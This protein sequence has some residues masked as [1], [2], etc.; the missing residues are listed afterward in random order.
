VL[1]GESPDARPKVYRTETGFRSAAEKAAAMM[2]EKD[3]G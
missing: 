3:N 1:R 2:D